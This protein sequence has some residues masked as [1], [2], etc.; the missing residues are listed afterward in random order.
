M[1]I[2]ELPIRRSPMFSRMTLIGLAALSVTAVLGAVVIVH[3]RVYDAGIM[4]LKTGDY[5]TA[6][7]ILLP[8]ARLCD[9]FAQEDIGNMYAYGEG[10]KRDDDEAL[11][12]FNRAEWC[13]FGKRS[14]AESAYVVGREYLSDF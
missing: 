14:A 10:V 8:L 4:A 2:V 13:S 5:E 6:Y 1:L 7:S 12:W 3:Q 9:S 11:K